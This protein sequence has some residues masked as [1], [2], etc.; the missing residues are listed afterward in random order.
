MVGPIGR[1][2]ACIWERRLKKDLFTNRRVYSHQ[3]LF[4]RKKLKFSLG[5]ALAKAHGIA[6]GIIR[7]RLAVENRFQQGAFNAGYRR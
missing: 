7:D 3:R 1:S 5:A 6:E 4:P 2:V